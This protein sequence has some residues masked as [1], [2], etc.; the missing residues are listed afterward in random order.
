ML[1]KPYSI[2]SLEA[3]ALATMMTS[4]VPRHVSKL[5]L[6]LP[7]RPSAEQ[8]PLSK[9]ISLA[10]R[11]GLEPAKY[12]IGPAPDSGAAGCASPGA[13]PSDRNLSTL[14]SQVVDGVDEFSWSGRLIQVVPGSSGGSG[15]LR[16]NRSGLVA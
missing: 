16:T 14:L 11:T 4:R 5:A 6:F 15:C 13:H 12:E 10:P 9:P 2:R 7:R 3:S 8:N 1:A